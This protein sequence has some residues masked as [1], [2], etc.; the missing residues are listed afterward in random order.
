MNQ[1]WY[2][3]TEPAGLARP[4]PKYTGLED[5]MSKDVTVTVTV[6]AGAKSKTFILENKTPKKAKTPN[7]MH[8]SPA[9]ESVLLAPFGK[10]Y[11]SLSEVKKLAK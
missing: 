7:F 9:S 5:T 6:K 4:S 11:V 3:D 1:V 10:V 8:F 2:R